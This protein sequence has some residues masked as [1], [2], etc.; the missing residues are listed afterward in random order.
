M[1]NAGNATELTEII[2]TLTK[3][4]CCLYY[5]YDPA[6]PVSEENN[7]ARQLLAAIEM[8]GEGREDYQKCLS[9]AQKYISNNPL[10]ED[11][12]RSVGKRISELESAIREKMTIEDVHKLDGH[13]EVLDGLFEPVKTKK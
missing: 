6:R 1:G 8:S 12:A 9:L 13:P 10:V 7:P 2:R 4:D 3:L 11:L 5:Y